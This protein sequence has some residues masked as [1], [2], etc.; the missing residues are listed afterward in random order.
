MSSLAAPTL[1]SK[2]EPDL[3]S[4]WDKDSS[5][6]QSE[7]S[8]DL[9]EERPNRWRGPP[10][11]WRALTEEDRLVDH[12]LSRERDN[13]LAI[14]L[15]NDFA[16]RRLKPDGWAPKRYWAAWPMNQDQVPRDD[17]MSFGH[18]ADDD[19]GEDEMFTFRQ[20][21]YGNDE[22]SG[23]WMEEVLT[24]AVI[25]A[26]KER[27]RQRQR[28]KRDVSHR[29]GNDEAKDDT[30]QFRGTSS[31]AGRQGQDDDEWL[32]AIP[33][34][35]DAMSA[36]LVKP[37]VRHIMT[38]L[39]RTLTVLHNAYVSAAA[40]EKGGEE[41][42]SDTQ[43]VGSSRSSR[44]RTQ[45]PLFSRFS[46]SPGAST[47][48]RRG[49]PRDKDAWT[50]REGE[51]ELDVRIRV[52]RQQKKRMPTPTPARRGRPRKDRPA[53]GSNDDVHVVGSDSAPHS[54]TPSQ[55]QGQKRR[56]AFQNYDDSDGSD[57][58]SH[59]EYAGRRSSFATPFRR[60]RQPH[61]D[62]RPELALRNWKDILSAAC[63]AGF[64]P[65]VIRRA[66]Q[67][68]SNLFQDDYSF[69]I[70]PEKADAIK[71]ENI[72]RSA[73]ASTAAS[74]HDANNKINKKK[75]S[76]GQFFHKSLSDL[77]AATTFANLDYE[78]SESE[79]FHPPRPLSVLSTLYSDGIS[80]SSLSSSL[81]SSSRPATATAPVP[82]P[83]PKYIGT[84]PETRRHYS[85][86][87]PT[88]QK[89]KS[90]GTSLPTPVPTPSAPGLSS[91]SP[92]VRTCGDTFMSCMTE[93]PPAAMKNMPTKMTAAKKWT[94][95]ST[96]TDF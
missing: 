55:N 7:A 31:A 61:K 70:L 59:E 85:G 95:P 12:S 92:D 15:Y 34:T 64:S 42:D 45:T 78:A 19:G 3:S 66:A 68:C 88:T 1:E 30:S 90:K 74:D 54:V 69:I 63:L 49:R 18:E 25:R 48:S 6:I 13:N 39:N 40:G 23:R 52:A 10:S 87:K 32:E 29:S 2:S 72:T 14:H 24:A 22:G 56:R 50:P 38:Q 96:E 16:L 8:S 53:A 17:L 93:T 71:R 84:E 79:P 89:R 20:R 28:R 75:S 67:R 41:S 21:G 26:G 94:E 27:L 82:T 33:S 9:H 76:N 57:S 35:D 81:S 47:S 58:V 91:L 44:D 51:T 80:S 11:S 77:P 43:A 73:L 62:R 86:P 65:D 46:S 60:Q 83:D 36:A 5:E 37:S 4:D